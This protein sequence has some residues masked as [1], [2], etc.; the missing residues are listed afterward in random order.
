MCIRPGEAVMEYPERRTANWQR[1]AQ[2]SDA[3]LYATRD[4]ATI[5]Q[6]VKDFDP[7]MIEYV[8]GSEQSEHFIA[9]SAIAAMSGIAPSTLQLR[10]N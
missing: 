8:V 4:L 7:S 9:V 10:H 2:K 5:Q 6:R 3:H 1:S